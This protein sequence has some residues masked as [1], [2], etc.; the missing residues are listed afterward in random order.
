MNTQAIGVFDSGVGG[1]TVYRALKQALPQENFLYLGDT[2][3]VPY[4]VRSPETIREYTLEA[5]ECLVKAGI[6]FLVVACNT[7]T[8]VAL[9]LL[10]KTYPSLPMMGVIDAGAAAALKASK[11]QH[12][13]VIATPATVAAGSYAQA[14]LTGNPQATLLAKATPLLVPLAEEGLLEG[15]IP[16]QLIE[17]Y[18]QDW[19]NLPA[20]LRPDSLILG[21]THFPVLAK[22]IHQVVGDKMQIIDSAAAVSEVVSA[23]FQAHPSLANPTQVPGTTQFWVTDAVERFTSV[24]EIFLGTALPKAA[25]RQIHLGAST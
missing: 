20:D 22:V 25:V 2:A 11:S 13:G 3:R 17:Y 10:Q 9:P 5:A 21:C 19:L 18:L 8:G 23:Y 24:A 4:G 14:I 6:K 1:L 7:A 16:R 15:D 12:I